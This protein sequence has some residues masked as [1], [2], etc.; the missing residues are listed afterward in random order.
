MAMNVSNVSFGSKFAEQKAARLMENKAA[1]VVD[2]A[3]QQAVDFINKQRPIAEQSEILLRNTSQ[4][5]TQNNKFTQILV[6]LMNNPAYS[7]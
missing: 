3:H 1:K 6:K 7:P 2:A 4:K 5:F